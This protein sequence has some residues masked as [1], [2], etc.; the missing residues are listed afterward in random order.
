LIE[1]SFNHKVDF[2]SMICC[3]IDVGEAQINEL[4]AN[5]DLGQ[6]KNDGKGVI[7]TLS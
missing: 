3:L 5:P 4:L 7:I 6:T 2:M 1:N